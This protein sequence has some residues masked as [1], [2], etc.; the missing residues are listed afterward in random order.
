[1]TSA[2]RTLGLTVAYDTNVVVDDVTFDIE[3][4]GLIAIVGPNGAGKTTMLKAILGLIPSVAGNVEILGETGKK[5]LKNA[6]YV[7][8]R[9]TVD[10]DFPLTVRDVVM[11]G[12]YQHLGLLKRPSDADQKIVDDALDA[13]SMND[14]ANRQIGELSGGQQ[15]RVFLARALAQQGDV[16]F[17][18]EP[19]QGVDA[20]TESAI[21]DVLRTLRN[22]GKTVLVVHH[23]LSTVRAYFDRVLL[24][25]KTLIAY[26]PVDEMFTPDLLQQTYGGRLTFFGDSAVLAS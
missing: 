11:Q 23:D 10:W 9:A 5:A 17:M 25:N 2:L 3:H 7:P 22:E 19:F 24:L 18:D 16:Y 8:Q 13:V 20:A 1:M 26:G 12:R 4:G 14:Y 15:Q 6:T 21:V